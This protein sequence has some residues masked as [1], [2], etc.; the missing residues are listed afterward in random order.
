M[1]RGVKYKLKILRLWRLPVA[2]FPL[3][4]RRHTSKLSFIRGGITMIKS[5]NAIILVVILSFFVSGCGNNNQ[6]FD[7]EDYNQQMSIKAPY[8]IDQAETFTNLSDYPNDY[9]IDLDDV[10]LDM[11]DDDFFNYLNMTKL[12]CGDSVYEDS[13]ENIDYT[14]NVYHN[15]YDI[16]VEVRFHKGFDNNTLRYVYYKYEDLSSD[17]AREIFKEIEN[18]YDSITTRAPYID[19][20]PNFKNK[21]YRASDFYVSISVST[22]ESGSPNV[23]VCYT[24]Y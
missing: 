4:K 9:L 11:S 19:E 20:N 23:T 7:E 6:A 5:K 24:Y 13:Y 18:Y 17:E 15:E 16:E 3:T 21:Q 12:Y 1:V 14:F 2:N 8:S 10:Y 22:Y